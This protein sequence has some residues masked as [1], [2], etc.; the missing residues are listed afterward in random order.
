MAQ[1]MRRIAH[2]TIF[3]ERLRRAIKRKNFRRVQGSSTIQD[4]AYS[5]SNVSN[6]HLN[7]GR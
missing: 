1:R 6:L 3:T 2:M 5:E 7:K 4:D